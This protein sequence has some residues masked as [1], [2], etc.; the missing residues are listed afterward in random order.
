MKLNLLLPWLCV[1][2][3]GAGMAAT[4]VSSS[5]K[6][7][8]L[9]RLQAESEELPQLR[10]DFTEVKDQVAAQ[11]NEISRLRADSQELLRLRGE[12]GKLQGE[13]TQLTKQLQTIQAQAAQAAQTAQAKGQQLASLQ[14]DIEA[15]RKST[16]QNQQNA[17]LNGCLNSLR[18][19]D[20]AKQQWALENQKRQDSLPAATDLAP[21]FANNL[22]PV[23]PA[24]GIYTINA[25]NQK[26]AC[27]V[28]GHALP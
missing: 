23:C 11:Q 3:L 18:Q 14:T 24:G 12:V 19:L 13:K 7:A 26:P 27:S 20:A 1:V 16:E 25:I 22:P 9:N 5:K 15:M 8:E 28:A 6:D 21:Y 17:A 4:Y 10:A 2:G